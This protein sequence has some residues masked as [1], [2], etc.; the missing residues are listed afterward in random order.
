MLLLFG[1]YMDIYRERTETKKTEIT[2]IYDVLTF[3]S[4][5]RKINNHPSFDRDLYGLLL[6]DSELSYFYDCY[7][8][9]VK[10]A[11]QSKSAYQKF[12]LNYERSAYDEDFVPYFNE[13]F[14][15]IVKKRLFEGFSQQNLDT[16]SFSVLES[17]FYKTYKQFS[18]IQSFYS[19]QINVLLKKFFILNRLHPDIIDST[20]RIISPG[21]SLFL[22]ELFIQLGSFQKIEHFQNEFFK[23]NQTERRKLLS[24]PVLILCP[25]DH[26][27]EAFSIWHDV[28]KGKGIIEMAT[29]TGKTVVGLM[30]IE[31][32][33]RNL[34]DGEKAI[35]RIFA[36]SKSILNQWRSEAI[37]KFG[38]PYSEHS[39]HES[40]LICSNITIHFNTVQ[41]I[42]YDTSKGTVVKEDLDEI[43]EEID[44]KALEAAAKSIKMD[45]LN[46][47]Y[48]SDLII[49]DEVHHSAAPASRKIYGINSK[50]KLGL[51]ATV[52]DSS[53][54][55]LSILEKELGSVVYQ[56]GLREAMDSGIL[57]RFRWDYNVIY[58]DTSEN[59]EFEELTKIILT[60]FVNINE[61]PSKILDISRKMETYCIDKKNKMAFPKK[62]QNKSSFLN[63]GD[64]IDFCTFARSCKI[65]LPE[66]W[67][68]LD[69]HIFKRREIIHTSKPKLEEATKKAEEYL[70]AGKKIIMF[71]KR[72][73]SCDEIAETLR[74]R[75]HREV[76]VVHSKIPKYEQNLDAFKKE[77]SGILIGANILNEGLDIPD[78]EIGINV[79]S[80]KTKLELIQR[81]GRVIRNKPGKNPVFVHYDAIPQFIDYESFD[82][83][84]LSYIQDISLA[85][86]IA[87][88]QETALNLNIDLVV[89]DT[90]SNDLKRMEQYVEKS[91]KD[92]LVHSGD[93]FNVEFETTIGPL[94]L[95]QILKPFYEGN[96]PY[97]ALVDCLD[98]LGKRDISDSEWFSFIRKSFSKTEDES[99]N[100]PGHYWIL[101]LGGRNPSKI[102]KILKKDTSFVDV[103]STLTLHQNNESK[104][105]HGDSIE[106]DSSKS[107]CSGV[108]IVDQNIKICEIKPNTADLN[109]LV[110]DYEM[111]TMRLNAAIRRNIVKIAEV[112]KAKAGQTKICQVVEFFENLTSAKVIDCIV[113]NDRIIYAIYQ[114][115]MG[116]AIGKCGENINRAKKILGKSIELVEYSDNPFFY[117]KNIF[118]PNLSIKAVSF[119]EMNGKKVALVKVADKDKGLA[120]GKNGRNIAK[121]KLLMAKHHEV[122]D[123]LLIE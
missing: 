64:F 74:N 12:A 35:V 45:Q 100:L 114:G 80:S 81:I 71:L 50:Q 62:Y 21:S 84:L 52:D 48:P 117:I 59:L 83:N 112:K 19:L 97:L 98:K 1:A 68:K 37:R 73:D 57:P 95:A 79:S 9:N 63:L 96:E 91:F 88:S 99:L 93:A 118:G 111:D 61:N 30:A 123:V 8:P 4:F 3:D 42:I 36:H 60:Q 26:Q 101:L 120:I 72:T 121:V 69:I 116:R 39:S 70:K 6:A 33:S 109:D 27:K 18:S 76:F 75:G 34:K 110:Y 38:L 32:L 7:L 87:W 92:N 104:M 66:D 29:G 22:L 16:E 41:K 55:K 15:K 67:I 94:K 28:N 65:K 86:D 58:L 51:S 102:I 107:S 10:E 44:N 53:G 2:S 13:H 49:V 90:N 5:L 103:A 115:D 11:Q 46:K 43:D 23:M 89:N 122:G 113:E 82:K 105:H 85:E 78:A 54:V 17:Q 14:S 25:W 20:N 47:L 31:N 77:K 40:S 119:V 106:E 24:S 108:A 56:F